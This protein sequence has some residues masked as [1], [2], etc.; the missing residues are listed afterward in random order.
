[1]TLR[2]DGLYLPPIVEVYISIDVDLRL[3]LQ[4]TDSSELVPHTDE[5]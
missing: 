1:M 2:A 5:R 3:R 4:G